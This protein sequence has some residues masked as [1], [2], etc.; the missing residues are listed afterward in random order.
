MNNLLI[1]LVKLDEPGRPGDR[2]AQ[3]VQQDV[4][5]LLQAVTFHIWELRKAR[6]MCGLL[7]TLLK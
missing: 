2:R 1:K 5:K 6:A 3:R 7:G 4:R